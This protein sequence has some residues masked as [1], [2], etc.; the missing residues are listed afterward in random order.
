[1][2]EKVY[3]FGA[4]MG[5]HTNGNKGWG[6]FLLEFP[7]MPS[8]E[9]LKESI[10]KRFVDGVFGVESRNEFVDLEVLAWCGLHTEELEDMKEMEESDAYFDTNG[11]DINDSIV[12][13]KVIGNI[14]DNFDLM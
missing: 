6:N 12:G 11:F 13:I 4:Y 2:K 8:Y 7:S 5:L 3:L 14:H 1:M 9:D 10:K